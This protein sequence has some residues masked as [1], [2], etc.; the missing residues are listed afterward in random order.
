MNQ[1]FDAGRWWLLVGKHWSENRKKY[2]LSLIAIAGLLLLWFI[3]M[4]SADGYRG[5]NSSM[6][7]STYYF[8]LFI[9]GCLYA[10]V[11]FADLG[12]KTRG[13]NYLVVPA[14]HLEK[15]LCSLFYGVIV[16]FLCYTA[17]FY[18]IDVLMVKVIN[19]IVYGH[20]VKNHTTGDVFVPQK[21]F[22]VFY[23][24]EHSRDPDVLLYLLLFYFVLQAAFISGSV[25]FAKFSFIKTVISL[26]L[27]G[28]FIAFF[29]GKVIAPILP[30]GS[31]YH[32]IT[33]YQVLTYKNIPG[34]GVMIYSDAATDKLITL[35]EWIGDTLLF[36]LKYAFA[37]LLWLATYYRLKEKEI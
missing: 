10:S 21:V 26:L 23:Q 29:I 27:I 19:A 5:I 11:L 31:Y 8:G 15:L 36:L 35:P 9:A 12:S 4:L 14:S 25:Y 16:F 32:G 20:W 6:Q 1:S 18:M 34:D 17:I 37:P 7:S 33:S 28:L 24:P 30:P 13:L 22:N 2:S 3:V